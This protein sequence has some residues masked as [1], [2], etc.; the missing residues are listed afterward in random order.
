MEEN[1]DDRG[2]YTAFFRAADRKRSK[3]TGR[4]YAQYSFVSDRSIGKHERT[5][6]IGKTHE[7]TTVA[8]NMLR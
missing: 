8:V 5:S 6:V 7:Q 3:L 1:G 2:D 4:P